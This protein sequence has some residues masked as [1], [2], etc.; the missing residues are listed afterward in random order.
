MFWCLFLVR[1]AR[2]SGVIKYEVNFE[3]LRTYT[4]VGTAR[5]DRHAHPPFY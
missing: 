5:H 4:L 1:A 3:G 2:F